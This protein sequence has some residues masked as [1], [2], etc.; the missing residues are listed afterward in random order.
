VGFRIKQLKLR[1]AFG[2][3]RPPAVFVF[4]DTVVEVVG[5]QI[6]TVMDVSALREYLNSQVH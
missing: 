2:V 5:G 1:A 4:I 3:F 6:P